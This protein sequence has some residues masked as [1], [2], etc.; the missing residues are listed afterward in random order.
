MRFIQTLFI[1]CLLLSFVPKASAQDYYSQPNKT[2]TTIPESIIRFTD[3]FVSFNGSLVADSNT[4]DKNGFGF[5]TFIRFRAGK[6]FEPRIGLAFNSVKQFKKNMY[7]VHNYRIENVTYN[8]GFVSIPFNLRLNFGKE[9]VFFIEGG[10]F[11]S[12]NV[13][14]R[15]SGTRHFTAFDESTGKIE[16][17]Y[18]DY[19]GEAGDRNDWGLDAGLGLKFPLKKHKVYIRAGYS[20]GFNDLYPYQNNLYNRYYSVSLGF[21]KNGKINLDW[22]GL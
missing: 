9:T 10:G 22:I 1:A 21:E 19:H 14:S 4:I 16:D 8:M 2:D 5:G 6:R 18:Q 13:F 15:S 17:F 20:H 11:V 7:T 3:Y 12:Y